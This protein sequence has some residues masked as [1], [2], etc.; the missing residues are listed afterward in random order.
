MPVG[1]GATGAGT[2][3]LARGVA[4]GKGNTAMFALNRDPARSYPRIMGAAAP[5]KNAPRITTFFSKT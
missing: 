5:L 4:F 2:E 1:F 3:S